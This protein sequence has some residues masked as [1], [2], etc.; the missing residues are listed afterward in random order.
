MLDSTGAH[1]RSPRSSRSHRSLLNRRAG[2]S[3]RLRAAA[4][5]GAGLLIA[6]TGCG[7]GQAAGTGSSGKPEVLA[8]F[9]PL[10]WMTTK[11]AGP[12][13]HVTSLTQPGVEPHDLELDPRQIAS[14]EQA[15]L[16]VHIKGVQPAVD[17]AIGEQGAAKAFDVAAAITTLPSTGDEGHADEGEG[18]A[19]EE[20][21]YDPH[22]WLDPARFAEAAVKLGER[23]GE[24]D[25][26]HA[27]AYA[28]RAKS[29]AAELTALDAEVRA[30]LTTCR[31]RTIVTSHSAFGYL[32]DR[33]GLKQV[34]I[35]GLDP[36]S[37]PSPARLAEVARVAKQEGVTTIFTEELVS[38]K[39]AEVLAKEVG[40]TTAVLNPIESRPRSGDYLS[41]ARANLTVLRSA[42][43]CS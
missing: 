15:D 31:S 40:A 32:A 33:Y 41:A 39:V 2:G 22:V 12:D 7:A 19:G 26:A 8:A 5:L 24:A 3:R 25:P 16:V 43:G 42:L 36:E 30:G 4:L 11:V 20:L 14:V 21:S 35:S 1:D 13:A 29:T 18:H 17:E 27:A 9:Y 34:G 10:E 28:D 6:V 38:P 23:L 37:E